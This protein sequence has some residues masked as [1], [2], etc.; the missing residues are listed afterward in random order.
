M[1][2]VV[3]LI[4]SSIALHLACRYVYNTCKMYKLTKNAKQDFISV[5]T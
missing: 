1:A 3:L 5:Y 4:N 2:E